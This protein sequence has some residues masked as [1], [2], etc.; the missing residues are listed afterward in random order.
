MPYTPLPTGHASARARDI[1]DRKRWEALTTDFK[2]N[3]GI[4]S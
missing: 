1:L 2:P 3:G 4:A